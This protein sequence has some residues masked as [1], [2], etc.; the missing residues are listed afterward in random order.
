MA[1][2]FLCRGRPAAAS[3]LCII[4]FAST[5]IR[6]PAVGGP[7]RLAVSRA[8]RPF[9]VSIAVV[10]AQD[11]NNWEGSEETHGQEARDRHGQQRPAK[12]GGAWRAHSQ[13]L[14]GWGGGLRPRADL[15]RNSRPDD[16]K[17][18]CRNAGREAR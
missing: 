12:R 14:R 10:K 16:G 3:P 17:D 6:L 11:T 2:T 5:N 13:S 8:S 1:Q 9:G 18:R 4:T 7:I 15:H